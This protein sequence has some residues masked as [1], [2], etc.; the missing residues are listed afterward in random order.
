MRSRLSGPGFDS[1]I[2]IRERGGRGASSVVSP[3][4][5]PGGLQRSKSLAG[6]DGR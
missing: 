5:R 6:K 1:C 4:A 3:A 2:A